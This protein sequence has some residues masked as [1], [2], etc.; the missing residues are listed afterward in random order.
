MGERI[1]IQSIL[2]TTSPHFSSPPSDVPDAFPHF[3]DSVPAPS[4]AKKTRDSSDLSY[5]RATGYYKFA[6]FEDLDEKAMRMIR[7][8]KIYPFGEIGAYIAHI[9]YSSDK[10]D[11]MAKTGREKFEIFVYKFTDPADEK[12]YEIMWDVKGPGYVRISPF[13]KCLKHKKTGPAKMHEANA[14]LREVSFHMTGGN[15][16]AQGYWLPYRCARAVCVKF[17]YPIAGALIPIFGPTFPDDC[18][19]PDSPH[20]GRMDIDPQEIADARSEALAY[21]LSARAMPVTSHPRD[22]ESRYSRFGAMMNQGLQYAPVNTSWEEMYS[23]HPRSDPFLN[24]SAPSTPPRSSSAMQHE[25]PRDPKTRDVLP[26]GSERPIWRAINYHPPP[27]LYHPSPA[28]QRLPPIRTQDH[29]S[30]SARRSFREDPQAPS[31]RRW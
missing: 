6:P 10:K 13:F 7:P 8:Y 12:P 11:V 28:G 9:P 1:A 3:V 21:R 27:P 26:P 5:S 30:S 18:V 17:C 22:E 29:P 20:F 4:K 2:N 15:R 23:R 14:G 24:R 25:E 31:D 19:K 16:I